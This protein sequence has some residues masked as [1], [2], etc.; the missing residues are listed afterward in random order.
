MNKFKIN[1]KRI[2]AL[3]AIV[4]VFTPIMS[5]QLRKLNNEN[6]IHTVVSDLDL[7]PKE[8]DITFKN[9]VKELKK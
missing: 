5:G 7:G 2:A 4:M 1:T 3:M 9:K 6:K 8:K